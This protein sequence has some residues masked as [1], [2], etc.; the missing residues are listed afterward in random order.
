MSAAARFRAAVRDK[1][2]ARAAQEFAEDIQLWNPLGTEPM[3]GRAAV[4][5]AFGGMGT[6]FQDFRHVRV[7]DQAVRPP[8]GALDR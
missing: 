1:D 2:P 5:A 3:T 6:L 8:V 7:L 4:A